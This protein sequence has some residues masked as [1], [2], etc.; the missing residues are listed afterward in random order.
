MFE[1]IIK[2]YDGQVICKLT[3]VCNYPCQ[4]KKPHKPYDDELLGDCT[5]VPCPNF[6]NS[7]KLDF[8]KK[9]ACCVPFK[10]YMLRDD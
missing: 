1:D 10:S 6:A 7:K 4:H 9:A 2:N 5:E 8:I 3:P